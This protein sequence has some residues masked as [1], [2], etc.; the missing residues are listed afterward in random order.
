MH[1]AR[2]DQHFYVEFSSLACK[3]M[4]SAVVKVNESPRKK[5]KKSENVCASLFSILA[6]LT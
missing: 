5:S 3:L 1:A 2:R 4:S 6:F